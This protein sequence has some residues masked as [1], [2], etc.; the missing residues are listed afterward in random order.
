MSQVITDDALI[1]RVIDMEDALFKKRAESEFWQQRLEGSD[2][3][4]WK[5]LNALQNSDPVPQ[6]QELLGFSPKTNV[7]R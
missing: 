5:Y 3:E 1:L 7:S 4:L 2:S 6:L